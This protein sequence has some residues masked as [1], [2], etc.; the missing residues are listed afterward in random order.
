MA[1]LIIDS[2]DHYS[3]D[4]IPSKWYLYAQEGVGGGGGFTHINGSEGRFGNGALHM[5]VLQLEAAAPI[6]KNFGDGVGGGTI[7][8]ACIVGFAFKA[9]GPGAFVTNFEGISLY[10]DMGAKSLAPQGRNTLLLIRSQ[11]DQ[12]QLY[13]MI[14]YTLEANGQINVWRGEWTATL[15]EAGFVWLGRTSKVLRPDQWYYIEFRTTIDNGG[16]EIDIR[17]NGESWLSLTGQDTY[18]DPAYP[19]DPPHVGWCEVVVGHLVGGIG[20]ILG[21]SVGRHDWYFDDLYIADGSTSATNT[22]NTFW[23]DHAI[24][25][26][27]VTADGAVIQFVPA[28]GGTNYDKVDDLT[29]DGDASYNVAVNAGDTDTFIVEDAVGGAGATVEAVQVLADVK[30]SGTGIAVA[31]AI[32]RSAGVNYQGD[33]F[34]IEDEYEFVRHIWTLD[35]ADTGV[36][37]GADF[38]G[39]E[40]GVIR[41][42]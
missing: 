26:R 24:R 36:I 35:P 2:F 23:G 27:R 22:V 14:G 1:L 13:G 8:T 29:A 7:S 5:S 39:F 38:N 21:Y 40:I 41:G 3:T 17:V 28:G 31:S 42:V 16:G 11:N 33:V 6:S 30:A 12:G 4:D 10:P 9:S 37:S 20:G 25:A 34:S 15:P 18:L 19:N 32:L